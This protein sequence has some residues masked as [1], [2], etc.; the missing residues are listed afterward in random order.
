MGIPLNIQRGGEGT[1]IFPHQE[2]FP[3][4]DNTLAHQVS[5]TIT[6]EKKLD[7]TNVLMNK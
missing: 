2:L 5:S 3:L 6:N 7:L 4:C 1:G